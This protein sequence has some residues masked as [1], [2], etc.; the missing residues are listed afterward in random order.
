MKTNSIFILLALMISCQTGPGPG[1]PGTSF[2]DLTPKPPMGWNSFDAYDS[3]INEAEFKASV[4]VMAE[5]L[6]EYGWEYAVIDYIWWHPAPGTWQTP[7]KRHGWGG[8]RY[9]TDGTAM[10]PEYTT[11]D[12][13]GRL[14]PAP[15]RNVGS[16]CPTPH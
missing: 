12:E 3:R 5:K 2:K 10:Y 8:I 6:L 11:I 4:D 13:Y 15:S 14:L 1:I 9:N 7:G 16:G